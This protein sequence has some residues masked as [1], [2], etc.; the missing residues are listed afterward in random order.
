M[1][2][3]IKENGRLILIASGSLLLLLTLSSGGEGFVGQVPIAS[4]LLITGVTLSSTKD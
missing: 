4:I 3:W 1:K 2:K